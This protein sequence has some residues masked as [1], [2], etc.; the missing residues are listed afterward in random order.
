MPVPDCG[1]VIEGD[2]D[3]ERQRKAGQMGE[4]LYTVVYTQRTTIGYGKNGKPK[5]KKSAGLPRAALGG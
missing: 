2:R 4:Q 5:T 3:K 1:R